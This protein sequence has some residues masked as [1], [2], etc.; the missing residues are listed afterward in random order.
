MGVL[1]CGLPWTT[2][3]GV[4]KGL[5]VAPWALAGH[6]DGKGDKKKAEGTT[7][8]EAKPALDTRVVRQGLADKNEPKEKAMQVYYL[9]IVTK[10]VD[11]VCAAYSAAGGVKFGNPDPGLG[12]ARTAP[13]P[14]GG[15]VGVRA[16]MR[17]TEAP[18]VRPYWLVKDIKAAVAAAQKAG[19]QVAMEPTEI[20]GHGT[21]AI[22]VHGG[23]DHGLWEK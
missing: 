5:S 7:Q 15:M 3:K 10:D 20:P 22:Y 19:G 23:V 18:I 14:G 2:S 6:Q 11:A 8:A 21:F 1:A 9:E 4:V 16:P 12:G 13:M 17:E